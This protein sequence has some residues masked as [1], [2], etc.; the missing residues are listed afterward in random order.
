MLVVCPAIQHDVYNIIELQ[1]IVITIEIRKC[2]PELQDYKAA[3]RVDVQGNH[4][5]AESATQPIVGKHFP[6]S[7]ARLQKRDAT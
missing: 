7:A 4:V 5:R 2:F 1:Q 3:L 6:T